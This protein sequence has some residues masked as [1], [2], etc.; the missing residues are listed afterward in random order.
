MD[1]DRKAF[2]ASFLVECQEGLDLIEQSLLDLESSSTPADSLQDV[3]RLAHTIKGNAFALGLKT[4]TA[5]AHLVEDLLDVLRER[6]VPPGKE[7]VSLLLNAVDELRVMVPAAVAGVEEISAQQQLLGQRITEQVQ[8][9]GQRTVTA[10][11]VMP[12]P[13]PFS[14]PRNETLSNIH[15]QT[16]RTGVAR[17]DRML[18]RTL[19]IVIAQGRLRRMLEE[20]KVSKALDA[21]EVH[22]EIE[23]LFM[24][25][26]E[27]MMRV[28]MVP[29]GPMFRQLGR[30]VR[31]MAGGVGKTARLEASGMDVEVDTTI[32]E[33]LKDPL[34]HMIRNAVDH[35]IETPEERRRQGK[36]SCGVIKLSAAHS[37]GNVIV[38]VEDD[39]AGIDKAK[40][41][42]KARRMDLLPHSN[43]LS[44]QEVYGFIFS[45]GFSTAEAVT[46]LSGRGVGLDV[47][48]RNIEKLRGTVDISSQERKG[49]AIT[50]RLP[51]TLAIIEGFS[52]RAGDDI[53]VIPLDHVVECAE[54]TA[55]ERTEQ[56]SGIFNLRG[57]PVPYVR[58]REAFA[59]GGEMP[60]REN[61]V[62]VKV[63][64]FRA[65]LAVDQLLGS[66]QAVVKPLGKL[67]HG[68]S[69][70][71]G[72]TILGDGRVGLIIDVRGLL[73]EMTQSNLQPQL[74]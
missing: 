7:V 2:L 66:M 21:L 4:L 50:I 36:P 60:E 11:P 63:G 48:R 23:H 39:G 59:T 6:S 54:I 32:F 37:S 26:Q 61:I 41:T 73:E 30:S 9:W 35:G 64:E 55:K 72:S 25:L 27:D 57:N 8:R 62:I 52:V 46:G 71:A 15:G 5:F 24:G 1:L 22:R 74:G 12:A 17:L 16:L 18:N 28:R 65:G 10:I 51:L 49:T 44:D 34:L 13:A 42:E 58:L 29:I 53:F 67:F 40:I 20:L 19:E 43:P 3:F 45:A 68:I 70:F 31:D 38:T 47:V 14:A 56:T 69:A 33:H